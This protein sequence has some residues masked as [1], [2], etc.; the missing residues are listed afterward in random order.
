M[1]Q[2][3][4][5]DLNFTYEGSFDPVFEHVSFSVDTQWKLGFI[6][7]NGKGKT[8]FLNLLRGKL[9]AGG[10]ITG[11][12]F[13][14]Y[15]PYEMP[16]DLSQT[17]SDCMEIWKPSVE[18][19]RV[20]IEMDALR[21]PSEFLY[22]PMQVLSFGERT[23]LMLAVLFAGENDFLL[24]DEPTNHLDSAT[25]SIVKEYLKSKTG[26]ILVSH[27]R[28][29]LDAVI[30][31]V[32]VLNRK[33]I[34]VQMGNFS[35]WWANKE[36]KDA[37]ARAENEKHQKEISKLKAASDRASRWAEK[38]ES[39]KIGYDPIKEHD[40][41]MDTRAYI[42]AKTKKMQSRVKAFQGRI[43]REIEE[44]EGLME[45]VE[46]S[47]KLKLPVLEHPKKRLISASDFTLSYGDNPPVFQPVTFDLMQGECVFLHGENGCGK[48]SLIKAVLSHIAATQFSGNRQNALTNAEDAG[49]AAFRKAAV[50]HG[51]LETASN[52]I[53][54]YI[55]QD[56]SGLKGDLRTYAAAHGLDIT[57]FFA[58]LN[59]L[60]FERVQFEKNMEEYSEGQKKKVCHR[61]HC[62]HR[63]GGCR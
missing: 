18:L 32:L 15:F 34:E 43:Q 1:A 31:H 59:Q 21:V 14:D 61:L 48:S 33:N 26:F 2:I 12:A 52:L 40:R 8:T 41:F 20:L 3:L 5:H 4:V 49:L 6:G 45:D 54:S 58:L 13:C 17:V 46:Y 60:D 63:Q 62:L 36:K 42:G 30:D 37:Y 39:T 9:D 57:Y 55:H 44:Q 11:N 23:K 47:W 22:R 38:N 27:D 28:D 53:V 7:R 19:W 56:T 10:S 25:R 24:I 16:E 51:K 35:S 50:E 29:L